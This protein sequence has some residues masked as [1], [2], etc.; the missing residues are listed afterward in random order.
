LAVSTQTF[1]PYSSSIQSRKIF[2]GHIGATSLV[3][4]SVYELPSFD[5]EFFIMDWAPRVLTSLAFFRC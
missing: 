2:D 1:V 5:T 3:R 4:F